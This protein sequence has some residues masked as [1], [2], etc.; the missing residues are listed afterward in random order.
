MRTPGRGP[1]RL[2][3]IDC[4][5]AFEF[6]IDLLKVEK[7]LNEELYEADEICAI[8]HVGDEITILFKVTT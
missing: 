6:G 1:Y 8:H 5:K 7:I 4:K 3:K 2:A